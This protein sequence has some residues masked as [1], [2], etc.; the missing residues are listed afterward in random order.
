[1]SRTDKD[2][3]QWVRA[4]DDLRSREHHCC[5]GAWMYGQASAWRTQLYYPCDLDTG[6]YSRCRR[7]EATRRYLPGPP[8][9]FTHAE[10]YGPDRA[11]VRAAS[12]AA[13][14]EH[15][16]YGDTDVEVPT[17]QHRHGGAW[18]WW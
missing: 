1:M 9:W 4:H 13:L 3:P 15:N 16:T 7:F 8:R 14:R 18:A 10:F 17:E 5:T 11:A 12:R 6:P 2:R